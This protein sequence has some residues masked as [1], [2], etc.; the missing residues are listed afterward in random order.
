MNNLLMKKAV[1]VDYNGGKDE[2]FVVGLKGGRNSLFMTCHLKGAKANRENC[3]ALLYNAPLYKVQLAL[4]HRLGQYSPTATITRAN[5]QEH[6]LSVRA[7]SILD[8]LKRHGY[9][10]KTLL[11]C[12]CGIE[13]AVV[14]TREHHPETRLLALAH[15]DDFAWLAEFRTNG[16]VRLFARK[17]S[18]VSVNVIAAWGGGD[19]PA[20]ADY[21]MDEYAKGLRQIG[22]TI[23]ES[24]ADL[25]GETESSLSELV[26]SSRF[27][28]T[29]K[30]PEEED[31]ALEFIPH[32]SYNAMQYCPVASLMN[33]TPLKTR[34]G[35]LAWN[36][37][38]QIRKAIKAYGDL[39]DKD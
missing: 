37:F 7:D 24:K 19:Q 28:W 31:I 25:N 9:L 2:Y 10:D 16:P 6:D 27:V 13:K 22:Y 1:S 4:D 11:R 20:T 23:H 17:P 21:K 36:D 29:P 35:I 3:L 14:A 26:R 18:S 5:P 33:E 15:E 12:E 39:C 8:W 32:L 34:R 30:D 38:G